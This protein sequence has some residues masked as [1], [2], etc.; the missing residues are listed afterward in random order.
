MYEFKL[1]ETKADAEVIRKIR[2][3]C[4]EF[5]TTFRDTITK[6]MQ[7]EWFNN[8]DRNKIKP[9][10]FL[11]CGEPVGYALLKIMGKDAWL[12]GGVLTEHRGRGLGYLIF[13][14]L[15]KIAADSKFETAK[16]DVFKTNENAIKLYKKL[17]FNTIDENDSVYVM[18]KQ[19]F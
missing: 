15:I 19:L 16:L 14:S 4:R 2:N 5:M 10:I 18:E 1:V 9:Y 13:N 7:K 8:F 17:G 11:E 12:T 3:D 6:D